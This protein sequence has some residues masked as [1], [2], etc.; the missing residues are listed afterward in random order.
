MPDKNFFTKGYGFVETVDVNE[1]LAFPDMC[2]NGRCKNTLGDFEC[3]CNQGRVCERMS[4]EEFEFADFP[5][6]S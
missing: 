3:R 5:D 6:I 1:C 2:Q 4:Y